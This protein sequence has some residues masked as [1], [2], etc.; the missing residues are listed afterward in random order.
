MRN[1]I[2]LSGMLCVLFMGACGDNMELIPAAGV[3][4]EVNVNLKLDTIDPLYINKVENPLIC[5]PQCDDRDCVWHIF[6]IFCKHRDQLQQ[7][8]KDHGVET[9]IHYPI[10]P[11]KQRCYKEWNDLSFPITEQIHHEELSIPC[12]QAMTQKEVD[13]IINLLNSFTLA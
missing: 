2:L 5:I 8:L 4:V 7:Y 6:P 13:E 9:Q 10:P 3:E 12:N 1:R 11:H